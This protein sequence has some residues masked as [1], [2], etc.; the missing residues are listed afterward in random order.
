M[1]KAEGFKSFRKDLRVV[2]IA[3]LITAYLSQAGLLHSF[4]TAS[5]DTLLHLRRSLPADHVAIVEI[6]DDDYASLFGST[7]PL[8]PSVLRRA[9]D[10]I[11]LGRPA[12]I[13]VDLETEPSAIMAHPPSSDEAPWPT[14]VW[15]GDSGDDDS[16]DYATASADVPRDHDGVVRR[17]LRLHDGPNGPATIDSF[18]WAIVREYRCST[19]G[20][21]VCRKLARG[22]S[23]NDIL[24]NFAGEGY[25]FLRLSLGSVLSASEGEAWRTQH[26]PLAGRIVLLGGTFRQA[27][28]RFVTPVGER[29]GVQIM[30]QA[31]ESELHG[32]GIR[33]MHHAFVFAL[34]ILCGIAVVLLHRG[35]T[36]HS[37]KLAFYS[38]LIGVPLLALS[39]SL[40]VFYSTA[41]WA[42]FVPVFAAV[43]IHELYETG[44]SDHAS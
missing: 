15:V 35:L 25:D 29:D 43:V 16:V 39:A 38:S 40:L 37:F 36:R 10:A 27:R 12:L 44:A 7:S 42:S 32:Q 13:G 9:L 6:T 31:V 23:D 18:P 2:L 24:L 28:D 3:S 19:E 17:Y 4:E 21:E 8:A 33:T 5:L 34:E 1:S 30:A 41:M 11:A 26:G 14:V 20:D 22:P